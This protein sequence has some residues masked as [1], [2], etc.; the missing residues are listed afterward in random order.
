MFY[1]HSILY[2]PGQGRVAHMLLIEHES[3]CARLA[4]EAMRALAMRHA[5]RPAGDGAPDP[6]PFSATP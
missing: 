2:E 6:A 3:E 5:P 1:D 4:S